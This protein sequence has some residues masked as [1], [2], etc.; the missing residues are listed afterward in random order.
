METWNK[1]LKDA[2]DESG[3]KAIQLAA[4]VKVSSATVSDWMSGE[5]KKIEG[6]RMLKVCDALNILPKWLMFGEGNKRA[7][8]KINAVTTAMQKMPEYKKDVVVATSNS[9]AESEKSGAA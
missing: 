4:T 2:F 7:D 3:L 1:R 6:D 5:I 8:Q 9:L